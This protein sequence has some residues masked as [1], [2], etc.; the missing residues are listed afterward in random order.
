MVRQATG[1]GTVNLTNNP[2]FTSQL[3]LLT[4]R[5]NRQ[6][7]ARGRGNTTFGLNTIADATTNLIGNEFTN[8]FNRLGQISHTGFN[9][10]SGLSDL[11]ARKGLSLADIYTGG[12]G[13]LANNFAQKGQLAQTFSPLNQATSLVSAG[14]S[15]FKPFS[16]SFGGGGGSNPFVSPSNPLGLTPGQGL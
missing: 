15:L 16:G 4:K 9:A 2:A 14:T 6:L 8:Q 11:S 12:A 1:E 7:G 10:S 3:D 13:N 5:L